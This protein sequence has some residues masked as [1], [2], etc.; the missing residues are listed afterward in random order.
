M[1]PDR[2]RTQS[3]PKSQSYPKAEHNDALD[4]AQQRAVES[5]AREATA[6]EALEELQTKLTAVEEDL[7]CVRRWYKEA[8]ATKV[9]ALGEAEA[10]RSRVKLLER[11]LFEEA[12]KMA[13]SDTE[14]VLSEKLQEVAA[15]VQKLE[16][17]LAAAG[18]EK[19]RLGKRAA[20]LEENLA[21]KNC[22]VQKQC[23][24]ES[25]LTRRLMEASARVRELETELVE[26]MG[27]A[28]DRVRE[29]EKEVVI[30]ERA[31]EKSTTQGVGPGVSAQDSV[32]M[33]NGAA[34]RVKLLEQ[35]WNLTLAPVLTLALNLTINVT[36]VI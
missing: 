18:A 20:D 5:Q 2:Y 23:N 36:I 16:E 30:A 28:T 26:A 35:E 15:K 1:R 33:Q 27:M 24:A 13:E 17:E 8:T 9:A 11:A 6:R 12:S 7:A 31:L 32:S 10:H 19:L 14:V 4:K 22:E 21:L 34:Q 29:L 25:M 3:E